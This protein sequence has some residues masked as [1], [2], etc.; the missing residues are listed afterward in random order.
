MKR[1]LAFIAF[2]HFSEWFHSLPLKAAFGRSIDCSII[3]LI[4]GHLALTVR[5]C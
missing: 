4:L 5:D 1:F 2:R 3:Q